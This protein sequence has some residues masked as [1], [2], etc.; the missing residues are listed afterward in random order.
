MKLL[1][2]TLS[3]V[4]MLF[5]T[6]AFAQTD[7]QNF[8]KKLKTLTGSWEGTYEGIPLHVSF[9]VTSTGHALMHEAT[10]PGRHEDPLTIFYLEGDRLLLTHY[11]DAG[12]RPHMEGK[13]SSDGKTVE[14][15][16]L[17]VA[18]YNNKQFG[19]MQHVVITM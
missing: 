12:N 6:V 10:S 14:F 5:S 7:A 19:H 13:M 2:F 3:F 4:L 9:R 16:L 15:D 11:C 17:D 8:F 18:N 1:R